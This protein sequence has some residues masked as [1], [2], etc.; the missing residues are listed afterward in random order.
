MSTEIKID[1]HLHQRRR[2]QKHFDA[3]ASCYESSAV[4]QREVC[5]R[6][7]ERLPLVT[8]KPD[9]IL[10]AGTGTGWG[11]QGLM[12]YYK[13]ARLIAMDL[14]VPMLQQAKARSSFFRR[15]KL[16]AADA[17]AI[18]LADESVD[19]I[20][21][22][23][24]LQWCQPEKVFAEFFRV[25]KPNGLLMFSTFGPDT[26]KELRYSWAQVDSH[27]HV[28]DF[29]DMHD[30]GDALLAAGLAEPV[31]DMDMMKLTY[32][33]ARS[34]MM[35]LKAIGAN[36]L[37]DNHSSGMVTPR[38]FQQVLKAYETFRCA[39]VLPASYE[40]VYG[41]AWKT[42]QRIKKIDNGEIK[43]PVNTVLRSYK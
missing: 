35:D 6:M 15:P 23:L 11:M 18:P 36:T 28:N 38:R 12:Q 41:H 32:D 29:V 34:V 37:V 40:I 13:S 7:L 14:S 31:M 5:N 39:G 17:E 42:E 33:D 10:D 26:L 20:F 1:E 9:V 24:M 3:R 16:L 27:K 30:L 25:L 19:L 22:N 8:L 43:I 4:L 2:I 21:S